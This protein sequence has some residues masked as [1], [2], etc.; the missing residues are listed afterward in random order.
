[1]LPFQ[2]ETLEA[3][4][5]RLPQAVAKVQQLDARVGM[6]RQHV[7]DFQ[8]GVRCIISVDGIEKNAPSLHLSF[9]MT[10]GSLDFIRFLNRVEAIPVELWPDTLLVLQQNVPSSCALH[11]FF[12][13]PPAW[14][15]LL[16]T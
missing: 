16:K 5:A 12:E 6:L 9:S 3:L 13:I 10:P 4:R 11:S 14:K 2:P 15:P 1:M 8:D 7:F